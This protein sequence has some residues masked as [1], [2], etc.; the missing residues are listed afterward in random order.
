MSFFD[1]DEWNSYSEDEYIENE[2]PI[3]LGSYA[4]KDR[5]GFEEVRELTRAEK[6][7]EDPLTKF[8][9][10]VAGVSSSLR[11]ELQTRLNNSTII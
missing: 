5:V 10:L 1:D 4:D 8:K 3:F 6:A 11:K 7:M 2:D 9:R